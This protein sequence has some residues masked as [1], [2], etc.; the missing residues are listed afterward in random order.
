MAHWYYYDSSNT[1]Q[2]PVN[3]AVLK[4]LSSNGTI[5]RNTI[6]ENSVGKQI[7]A[8]KI[9]GLFSETSVPKPLVNPDDGSADSH[10]N[11]EVLADNPFVQTSTHSK[12]D[13]FPVQD[14]P[15]VSPATL[16]QPPSFPEQDNPFMKQPE[17]VSVS[18]VVIPSKFCSACGNSVVATATICPRCGSLV[19]SSGVPGQ[20]SRLVYILLAIF[21][22]GFGVHDF[23]AGHI[24]N[25]VMLLL[26][27]LIGI[28]FLV[29]LSVL[30][31]GLLSPLLVLGGLGCLS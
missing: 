19:A 18:H 31:V 30:S 5:K 12:P 10:S 7:Q 25:G 21:L 16:P 15:F 11:T 9:Q 14:N 8:S 20:V 29:L 2:G 1:K 13:I 22:G 23:Y 27:T 6:I 4:Y 3:G 28:P 26:F 17:T 24:G